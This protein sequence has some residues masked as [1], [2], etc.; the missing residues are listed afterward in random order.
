MKIAILSESPADQA[1]IAI[2]VEAILGQ[3]IEVVTTRTRSSGLQSTIHNV[4]PTLK[5]LHYHR[6]ADALIVSIDSDNSLIHHPDHDDDPAL[7]ARSGCRFC[8]LQ[9]TVDKT[10]HSVRPISSQSEIQTA[11][12]IAVPAI[13]AWYQFP[14]NADC[15]ESRWIQKQES[16]ATA[17]TEIK[18]LKQAVYG[19]DRPSQ[20][21]SK[22]KATE[23]AKRL[24]SELK[25]LERFF[26]NSFG[27]FAQQVRDWRS[28]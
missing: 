19:T 6:I 12:V 13:E 21:V 23:H 26:P 4:P 3:T 2:L 27:V 15:S 16:G 1:A 20:H 24:V 28:A 18:Q 5:A 9:I 8:S 14:M 25:S 17:P 11:T 10:L 7:H 22:A